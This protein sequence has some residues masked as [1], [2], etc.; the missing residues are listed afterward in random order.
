VD[1]IVP[2]ES[3]NAVYVYPGDGGSPIMVSNTGGGRDTECPQFL[4]WSPDEKFV[5]IHIWAAVP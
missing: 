4:S 2:E 1:D 3:S 5:Y